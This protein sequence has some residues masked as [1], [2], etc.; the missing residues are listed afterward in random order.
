MKVQ[1]I[2]DIHTE[3]ESPKFTLTRKAP[4]LLLAGNIGHHYDRK[5]DNFICTCSSLFDVVL[6]VAGNNEYHADD[7][8][9]V[10]HSIQEVFS[11]YNN[12][13]F[14]DRSTYTYVDPLNSSNVTVF[15]GC[16]LW[17]HIPDEHAIAAK[18]NVRD[19]S[20]I[21]DSSECDEWDH[22]KCV[23]VKTT[24]RWHSQD[25]A[26]LKQ[27]IL[28]TSRH[29]HNLVILTHHVPSMEDTLGWCHETDSL[30]C[31]FATDLTHMM[32]PSVKA[33]FYGGHSKY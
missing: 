27:V 31:T 11:D 14:L 21:S 6:Y 26:W 17:T 5:F 18:K 32:G 30:A 29:G 33:W 1:L 28:D 10:K 25:V 3:I 12:V 16:T 9:Y 13:H 4:V 15:A 19:Y 7:Y 8:E 20:Y 2:S 23:T 22:V 24:N